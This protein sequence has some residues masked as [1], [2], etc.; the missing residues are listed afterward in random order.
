MV[1][2]E[3]RRPRADGSRSRTGRVIVRHADTPLEMLF[4]TEPAELLEQLTL[5]CTAPG[6]TGR[7]DGT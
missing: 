3:Y 7:R 5:P 2:H 6:A 4:V 1:D